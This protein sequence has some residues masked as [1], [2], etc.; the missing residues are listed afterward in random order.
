[1][2]G[3]Q[4]R[5]ISEGDFYDIREGVLNQ[6][7]TGKDVPSLEE[8]AMQLKRLPVNK[9]F[10]N[11]L[12]KAKN[13][14]VTLCQPRAGVAL[15][16]EQISLLNFLQEEGGAELLTATIDSYTRN[17]RYQDAQKYFLESEQL[18]RSMLNGFP[19]INHGVSGCRK[20]L[21]SVNAPIQARHGTPDA[22]LLSEIIHASGWTSNEGGGICYNIPY[23]KDIS[24]EKS[25][26]DWQYCDRLVGLYQEMG[27]ELNREFFAPLT[28]T[29]IPPF[30]GNSIM[31]IEALLAAEQGVYNMTVG[32]GQGGQIQQDVAAMIALR[33]QTEEYLSMYG[34]TANVTTVFHQWM[35]GFP[36]DEAQAFGLICQGSTTATLCNATKVI[37]KTP[38]EAH[39]VP[40]KEANA[41]GLRATKQVLNLLKGQSLPLSKELHAEVNLIKA[42]TK[43]IIDKV[44][45]LGGGDLAKGV[46]QSFRDGILDIP[47]APSKHNHNKLLPVRDNY[48]AI[49]ILDFGNLPINQE[50]KDLHRELLEERSL[51]EGRKANFQMVIDDIFAV[52]KGH[53]VG[54]PDA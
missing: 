34:Y 45:E 4:N 51:F 43:C 23:A 16:D 37:V 32:L 6:W 31:I 22:R 17:N 18:G 35:G 40:T 25:L 20:L 48:G 44:Y 13:E 28:A 46:V 49:R 15:I 38:H 26:L 1:M 7:E 47:F 11:C 21:D 39:G 10:S 50:I 52:S 42:E 33:Q 29:L 2:I 14:K 19:A 12:S 5:K 36:A 3:I 30:L 24:L 41:Q 53:L 8:C 9:Q 27:A 54:R